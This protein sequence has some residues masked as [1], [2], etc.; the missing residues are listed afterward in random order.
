[1]I[2]LVLTDGFYELD[3]GWVPER[4]FDFEK[5]Y[6]VERGSDERK[7][8]GLGDGFYKPYPVSFRIS[9]G[10]TQREMAYV[11]VRNLQTLSGK[12]TGLEYHGLSIPIE[13]AYFIWNFG[14]AMNFVTGSLE[15]VPER[16]GDWSWV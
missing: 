12:I 1:M 6:A 9:R 7:T 13:R 11:F 8:M 3:Q 16:A 2:R 5:D 4:M 10:F 15:L 14:Q